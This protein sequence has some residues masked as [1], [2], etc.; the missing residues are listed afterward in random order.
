MR[1][2]ARH[3]DARGGAVMPRSHRHRFLSPG[4]FQSCQTVCDASAILA[5]KA[6]LCSYLAAAASAAAACKFV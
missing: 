1:M 5:M 3:R 2:P 4:R 6:E